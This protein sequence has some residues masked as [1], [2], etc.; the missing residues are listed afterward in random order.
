MTD[1]KKTCFDRILTSELSRPLVDRFVEL[2]SGTARAVF[3]VSKLWKNGTTIEI[4]FL[5]GTTQQKDLVKKVA[6]EWTQYANLNFNFTNNPKATIRIAF[7]NDGAW[8]Y[9]GTDA[10]GIP[11]PQPTMNFGWLDQAVI[12]HEFGH[13]IGM[14]HEHQN[15][16]DNPIVW[17]HEEVI[18]DLSGAPNYWDL[19]TIEHNMFDKYNMSQVNGS[20]FDPDSVMLYSFPAAWTQ[21]GVSTEENDALSDLDK[22]FASRVYPKGKET[23]S[24]PIVEAQKASI[25][26][27][28]EE[29]LYQLSIEEIDTYVIETKGSTDLVMTLYD[30]DNQILQ[31]SDDDGIGTNPRIV[32]T[33][34]PG[35]Y[36]IQIRHYNRSGGTG[37]YSI[38]I[39]R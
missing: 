16:I 34:R 31:Q 27:P 9:I 2:S 36:T 10:L 33:L 24:L 1:I 11:S 7:A 17:D 26:K 15:P 22:A 14:V 3:L 32:R 18:K 6:V 4:S 13:M 29:D 5:G 21:N 37:D 20:S 25:G 12:L 35:N 19:A 28:G 30:A 23:A 38:I 39:F 8:S